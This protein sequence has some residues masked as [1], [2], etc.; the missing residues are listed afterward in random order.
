VIFSFALQEREPRLKEIVPITFAISAL[1][2]TYA[3]ITKI[4][5]WLRT[6]WRQWRHTKLPQLD[7]EEDAR[8]ARATYAQSSHEFSWL[9]TLI[10][11]ILTILSI[12]IVLLPRKPQK[13]LGFKTVDNLPCDCGTPS[14]DQRYKNPKINQYLKRVSGYCE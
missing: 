11:L 5:M 4:I 3:F 12:T 2:P 6:P 14:V 8:P 9:V 13:Y 7:E 1:K 10:N